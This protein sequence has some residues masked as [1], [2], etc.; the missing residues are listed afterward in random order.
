[1]RVDDGMN[2]MF[3]CLLLFVA[4]VGCLFSPLGINRYVKIFPVSWNTFLHSETNSTEFYV[5]LD[6]RYIVVSVSVLI[7]F[8][9]LSIGSLFWQAAPSDSF[10]LDRETREVLPMPRFGFVD[11]D[12]YQVAT[13]RSDYAM[14]H[15]KYELWDRAVNAVGADE[16][17]PASQCYWNLRRF[18][19][20]ATITEKQFLDYWQK[21]SLIDTQ[22]VSPQRLLDELGKQFL[23]EYPFPGKELLETEFDFT[24]AYRS[25]AAERG[26][27]FD[28]VAVTVHNVD[29][30]CARSD[31]ALAR[32]ARVK[33]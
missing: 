18:H 14:G 10:L 27:V 3:L 17:F 7:A 15:G 12:K 26:M 24:G 9:A 8:V 21:R 33:Q 20:S 1:M 28:A 30:T 16:R 4:V 6:R 19:V 13:F 29:V 11:T 5:P 25:F 22:V 32:R 2:V 31:F 23:A